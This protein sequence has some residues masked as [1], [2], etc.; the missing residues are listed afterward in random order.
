MKL[1]DKIEKGNPFKVPEGYF[2]SLTDRTMAAIREEEI[3]NEAGQAGEG[4]L[5]GWGTVRQASAT[6]GEQKEEGTAGEQ[7]A[8]GTAGEQIAGDAEGTSRS[9]TLIRSMKPFLALAAA[10][11]GFAVIAAVTVRLI[12]ANH[13]PEGYEPGTSLYADLAFEEV[14]AFVLENELSSAEPVSADLTEEEI[15]SETIIEYL[16]TEGVELNDIYE[17]L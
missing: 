13:A 16:M 17:L 11:I 5:S 10:I 15:S 14:D 12:G 9:R 1:N 2:D 3:R 8:E 6:A 4:D 7:K